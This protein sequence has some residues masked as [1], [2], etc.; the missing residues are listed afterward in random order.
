MKTLKE[1]AYVEVT[2]T[3]QQALHSLRGDGRAACVFVMNEGDVQ[4]GV[5]S[6]VPNSTGAFYLY[7][8]TGFTLL[9]DPEDPDLAVEIR[10]IGSASPRR[11]AKGHKS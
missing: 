10:H 3:K 4:R 5:V 9:L 2:F 11:I 1:R 7:T 8:E 6:R